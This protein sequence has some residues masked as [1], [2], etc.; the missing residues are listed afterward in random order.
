LLREVHKLIA[1][2]A[3]YIFFFNPQYTLYGHSK[4]M[5]KPK[6]TF[7]YAIGQQFWTIEK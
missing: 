1:D 4:R 7:Q 2:D 6:D 3:P 5:Q